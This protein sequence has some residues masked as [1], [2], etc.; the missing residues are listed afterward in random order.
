MITAVRHLRAIWRAYAASPLILRLRVVGRYVLCPFAALI[1][2]FPPAGRILDIGCGD[3]LLLFL[4]SLDNGSSAR[5]YTGID[6]DPRKIGNA[7]GAAIAHAEFHVQD[8]SMLPPAAFECVSIIDV[9][10]LLPLE[11]WPEFLG[12]SVR[13]LKPNGRLI[14][15]EAAAVPRWKARLGYLQELVAI[16]LMGMT[17]GDMPHLEPTDV[18]RASIEAAGAKVFRIERVDARRPHAHVLLVA[19]KI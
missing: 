8:V 19:E 4:L 7:K 5:S 9:L 3:G 10:Y 2:A 17:T 18:Y 15:K 11:R 1:R 6:V 16:K 12:H 13:A 14:V